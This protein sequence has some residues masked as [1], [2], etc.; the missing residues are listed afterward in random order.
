[1]TMNAKPYAIR[2]CTRVYLALMALTFVTFAVGQL[3]L[4]GLSV[5]LLVLGFA[6]IK[7]HLVGDFFMGLRGI[8]GPWRWVILLWLI[9][10]GGLITLAF[11]LTA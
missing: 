1:M 9:L 5:S 10:P 3:G 6:L 7:G 2:P 8:Q 11:S 4:K